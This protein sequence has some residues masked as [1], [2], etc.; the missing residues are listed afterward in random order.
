MALA[1]HGAVQDTTPSKE[2][3]NSL[4]EDDDVEEDKDDNLSGDSSD[5]YE[6]SSTSEGCSVDNGPSEED[7]YF[8]DAMP[9]IPDAFVVV[10]EVS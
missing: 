9:P 2:K 8:D 4:Q 6:S 7:K 1:K 3:G 5:E 10:D